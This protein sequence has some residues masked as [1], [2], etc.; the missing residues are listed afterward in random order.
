MNRD[1]LFIKRLKKTTDVVLISSIISLVMLSLLPWVTVT[2]TDSEAVYYNLDML[3]K[4]EDTQ[5][6]NI[7]KYLNAVSIIFWVVILFCLVAYIGTII[8]TSKKYPLLSNIIFFISSFTVVFVFLIIMLHWNLIHTISHIKSTSMSLIIQGIPISYSFLSYV[9]NI[10]VLFGSIW[11]VRLTAPFLI[12]HLR[13]SMK[14]RATIKKL[15]L[16]KSSETRQTL[17]QEKPIILMEKEEPSE[18]KPDVSVEKTKSLKIDTQPPSKVEEKEPPKEQQHEVKPDEIPEP[19]SDREEKIP[20]LPEEKEEDKKEEAPMPVLKQIEDTK[21]EEE[22]PPISP[23][24]EQ[25]LATAVEKRRTGKKP[26][27]TTNKEEKDQ[28]KKITVKCPGC[29]HIFSIEKGD[30]ITTI[31]CPK[32]GKKGITNK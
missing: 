21:P 31:E 27:K 22:T 15:N 30:D 12:K 24:F 29:G 3:V 23:I 19:T 7:A 4:T 25:A 9:A 2:E 10:V 5:L 8:Y 6:N 11:Y 1:E 28:K 18:K 26:E 14:R 32:C 20:P 17:E 16:S 13:T